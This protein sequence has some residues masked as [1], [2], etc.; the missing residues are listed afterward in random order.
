MEGER[1]QQNV[2]RLE[3]AGASITEATE[4]YEK[5]VQYQA[6][7]AKRSLKDDTTAIEH[8]KAMVE[9]LRKKIEEETA[10]AER[11]ST[12]REGLLGSLVSI[13]ARL[14]GIPAANQQ[15]ILENRLAAAH[16]SAKESIGLL[17]ASL[18]HVDTLQSSAQRLIGME[19]PPSLGALS[20]VVSEV[21]Q[22]L[23]RSGRYPIADWKTKLIALAAKDEFEETITL[24]GLVRELEGLTN[25]FDDLFEVLAGTSD[26][27]VS[28]AYVQLG[29]LKQAITQAEAEEKAASERK[30]NLAEGGADYPNYINVALKSFRSDL[31]GA[32]VQV[33]CDLIEPASEEWQAAIE[34]YM[35]GARFNFVVDPEWEARAIEFVRARYL[36]ANVIQGAL[37]LK[38]A[39]P[40]R[41]SA[42]SIIHELATQHPIASAFL[43]DQ[44]GG[45]IKVHSLEQLRSTSRGVMKD[46]KAAGSRTMFSSGAESLVF[47]KAQ[48]QKARE[49]AVLEH[50]AADVEL[51]RLQGVRTQLSGLLG[52]LKGLTLPSF[53]A[54]AL[55]EPAVRDIELI[56]DDMGRLD[57]TEVEALMGEKAVLGLHIKQQDKIILEAYQRTGEAKK[58]RSEQT[59][60]MSQKQLGLPA[61]RSRVTDEL[62][63]LYKICQVNETLSFVDLER[64]VDELL[65]SGLFPPSLPDQIQA[66]LMKA[67]ESTSDVRQAV[68]DYNQNARSD[69]ALDFPYSTEHRPD[70]FAPAYGLLV[71]LLFRVREQLQHQRGIGLVKNLDELRRS[72]ASF[73]N[74]F[75]QEFCLSIRN[76]VEDGV[77]TLR[78]LNVEL[79]RLKFGTDRF[80][81]DWSVWVPEFK[82]Y[83]DF[84]SAAY[85]LSDAQES[86]DLFATDGLSTENSA[87]RDKL[88]DLLLS[89]D[90]DRAL[91]ELQRIADYRNYRRYEIWKETDSGSK[92][93][94]SEWGTGSGGQLETPA[95]IV[96]AAVV[97][98]RLKHFEKGVNLK[99]LVNDESFAK[100]DERRAHDVIKFI[101]DSLG[102]Q[103]I[104]A[105][106]TK[107]AGALKSEFTKEWC[108][109]RTE[110][111]GN[112]EVDFV[113]EADERE[114]STDRLRDLWE[115]RRQDV[116]L[117]AQLRFEADEAQAPA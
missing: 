64:E 78:L 19:F 107:H 103:L 46:G 5:A 113:S 38:N 67:V 20:S 24:M 105:M 79:E 101:R 26:S 13:E 88:V 110:A 17:L 116:R 6:L 93:A 54:V 89:N 85:D 28:T 96:R 58:E 3:L 35:G 61:R 21:A 60:V 62:Q 66:L 82:E 11:A 14:Q 59:L 81:I 47:G 57:L 32:R 10:S 86:G 106:P 98:N 69:E 53:A 111:E 37:C 15:A 48:Q 70:D 102:M 45:V 51:K 16:K 90:Q 68:S 44:F 40:E 55:L 92:V 77:K 50:E 36:K 27:L 52:M 71:R 18:T 114:L 31:P 94:L 104:C 42:E 91:K 39:K 12:E 8:A 76:A 34:G 1:I 56:W 80:R 25:R 73:R 83:Y 117:Q 29:E 23:S 112:G 33:L 75:T 2:S 74:V 87:V 97:T 41:V 95:Y 43:T 100:M 9:G 72:E 65:E 84:F 30:K 7:T 49:R 4:A 22:C 109:T 115:Q 63:K 99:L 108:F